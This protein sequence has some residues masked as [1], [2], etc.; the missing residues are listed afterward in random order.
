MAGTGLDE[1]H[2]LLHD[3]AIR[4][5]ELHRESGGSV[6]GA[7]PAICAHP[8]E[9]GTVSLDTGAARKLKLDRLGDFRGTDALFTFLRK[10]GEKRKINDSTRGVAFFK[11]CVLV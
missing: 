3:L 9:L 2:A 4:A 10:T 5:F 1:H 6:G 8:A 7:A 11:L